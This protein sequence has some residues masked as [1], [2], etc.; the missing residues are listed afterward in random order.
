M[1][2]CNLFRSLPAL[3]VCLTA[4]AA[5]SPACPPAGGCLAGSGASSPRVSVQRPRL[6]YQGY[7]VCVKDRLGTVWLAEL[8]GDRQVAEELVAALRGRGY[9]AW[10]AD[11]YSLSRSTSFARNQGNAAVGIA[12]QRG[13]GGAKAFAVGKDRRVEALASIP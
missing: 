11:Y 3:L 1:K 13:P 7:A 5:E 9:T 10:S 2:T 8:L 6:E 4:F 12:I